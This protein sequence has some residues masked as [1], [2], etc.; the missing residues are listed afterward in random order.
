MSKKI[1]TAIRGN[2]P[3]GLMELVRVTMHRKLTE[4]LEDEKKKVAATLMVPRIAEDAWSDFAN[5][6]GAE[7]GLLQVGDRV[8]T[9]RGGQIPGIVT[10]ISN[11]NV[12]FA[13]GNPGG[14]TK[15]KTMV[16]PMSN[17][18]KEDTARPPMKPLPKHATNHNRDENDEPICQNCDKPGSKCTCEP[19]GSFGESFDKDYPNRKDQRA[20]Y[21]KSGEKVDRT[22]RPGGDPDS[23]DAQ[24]RQHGTR[25][26]ELSASDKEKNE[27]VNEHANGDVTAKCKCGKTWRIPA[28]TWEHGYEEDTQCPKCGS[29]DWE[30]KID[31]IKED[32]VSQHEVQ[33]IYDEIGDIG[34][35]ELLCGIS[36]LRVNPQ[37][38]VISYICE[39]ATPHAVGVEASELGL[40]PGRWPLSVTHQGILYKN[41]TPIR[42]DE[43][44]IQLYQYRS[45]AGGYL[46]VYND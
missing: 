2:D 14:W 46:H 6:Y 1:L 36:S 31:V 37:G 21:Y 10:K 19:H 8:R 26:R 7:G 27:A 32:A 29:R 43:G 41:P 12:H 4:A 15:T 23:W 44:D 24:N 5:S 30:E 42:D 17:I 39:A 34:E 33:R 25:R 13:V 45:A 40:Q 16:T 38:Q 18:V 20:P 22:N 3:K 28:K 35:T 11:G 9:K